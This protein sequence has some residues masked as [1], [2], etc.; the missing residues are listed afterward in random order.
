M[1]IGA[2]HHQH[3]DPYTAAMHM[4]EDGKVRGLSGDVPRGSLYKA[5]TQARELLGFAPTWERMKDMYTVKIE[6][7]SEKSGVLTTLTQTV[8]DKEAL[9]EYQAALAEAI[10]K[11]GAKNAKK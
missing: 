6:V 5:F 2:A 11:L 4:D 9:V 1:R 8:K 10:F 7:S 3:G